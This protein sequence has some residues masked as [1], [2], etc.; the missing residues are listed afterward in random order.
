MDIFQSYRGNNRTIEEDKEF[1]IY[2]KSQGCLDFMN[3]IN[4]LAFQY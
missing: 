3:K 4:D 2:L 1:K